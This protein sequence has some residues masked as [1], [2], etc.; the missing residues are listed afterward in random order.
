L[1]EYNVRF[2]DPEAQVVVPL[3]ADDLYDLLAAVADGGLNAAPRFQDAAAVTVVLAAEG[4]PESPRTGAPIA[5]LAADGQSLLRDDDVTIYHAGTARDD[6]G[7]FRT[8]G[9][10]V[11]AVTALGPDEA[12]ARDRAYRVADTITFPGQVRRRDI[13][14]RR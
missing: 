5:G 9:G 2:G 7:T 6:D 13:A 8:A 10:R 11:L 12:S 1:L 14:A 3:L 4:Y